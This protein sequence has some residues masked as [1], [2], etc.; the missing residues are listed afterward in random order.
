MKNVKSF[1]Q[2]L[3]ESI[4]RAISLEEARSI[5]FDLFPDL[6]QPVFESDFIP[7]TYDREAWGRIKDA[8]NFGNKK[9][10]LKR[11]KANEEWAR[12]FGEEIEKTIE[13]NQK[14]NYPTPTGR[15]AKND[16]LVP[17]EG[18]AKKIA[19][20]VVMLMGNPKYKKNW[21]TTYT[22]DEW[23]DLTGELIAEI[24]RQWNW[25]VDLSMPIE[26]SESIFKILINK[27][28]NR[29]SKIS[30]R[31]RK[32]RDEWGTKPSDMRR[33]YGSDDSKNDVFD[34][35]S[36]DIEDETDSIDLGKKEDY[37]ED[38]GTAGI[39]SYDSDSSDISKTDV[40][41][42]IIQILHEDPRATLSEI[43]SELEDGFGVEGLSDLYTAEEV[44][45][46]RRRMREYKP[47]QYK[48][49]FGK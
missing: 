16:T 39:S 36:K 43:S 22:V 23:E 28:K 1:D 15:P 27:I 10:G 25:Q 48:T 21:S 3:N 30:D 11:S 41:S 38:F 40:L 19:E 5:V 4:S 35:I 37:E 17:T 29:I 2:F 44:E 8:T 49:K 20:I 14:R 7:S 18:L 46:I 6:I 13:R 45:S 33:S 12:E 34:E 24:I 47:N 32:E 42:K 26:R 31:Y 9:K